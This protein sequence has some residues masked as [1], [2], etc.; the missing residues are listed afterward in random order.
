MTRQFASRVRSSDAFTLIELLVVIAIIATLA[1]MLLPVL[2]KAKA[3]GQEVD[4]LNNMRQ[5]GFAVNLYSTDNTDKLPL[6]RNWGPNWGTTFSMRPEPIWLPEIIAPYVGG[7]PGG[8]TNLVPKVFNCREGLKRLQSATLANLRNYYTGNR[9]NSYV[10]NHRYSASAGNPLGLPAGMS[11]ATSIT[12]RNTSRI[13][14]PS[15]A[16]VLWEL[17]YWNTPANGLLKDMPHRFG[18]NLT[19]ADGHAAHYKGV[20]AE[21]DWWAFHSQDGWDY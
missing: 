9:T 5:I 11:L 12:D 7:H 6:V 21:T 8:N 10:W 15:I 16:V 1:G 19:Y 13:L 18:I 14:K 20:P 17:P 4:C 2:S 3:R